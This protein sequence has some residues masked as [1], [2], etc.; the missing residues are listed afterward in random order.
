MTDPRQDRLAQVAAA[1]DAGDSRVLKELLETA[2][3]LRNAGLMSKQDFSHMVLLSVTRPM[4]DAQI[5]EIIAKRYPC[6]GNISLG[7]QRL[8]AATPE[9]ARKMMQR[10][11]DAGKRDSGYQE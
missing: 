4:T 3:E 6:W 8:R 1:R 5:K 11:F 2:A 7:G 9:A 10:D